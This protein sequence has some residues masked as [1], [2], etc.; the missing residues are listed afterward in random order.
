MAKGDVFNSSLAAPG[1]IQPAAGVEILIKTVT[2]TAGDG[3]CGW[4]MYDGASKGWFA[5]PQ[6]KSGTLSKEAAVAVFLTNAL[7]IH[8]GSVSGAVSGVQVK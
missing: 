4:E 3:A 5:N 7:Y 8:T 2:N 1:A 6:P